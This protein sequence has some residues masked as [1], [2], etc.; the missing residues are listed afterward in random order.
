[1]SIG[2]LNRKLTGLR[3]QNHYERRRFN[4]EFPKPLGRSCRNL[5]SLL[6]PKPSIALIYSGD[7][8][9]TLSPSAQ[10]KLFETL[11]LV[12]PEASLK[13]ALCAAFLVI[14]SSFGNLSAQ[15]TSLRPQDLR[16]KRF[17]NSSTDSPGVAVLRRPADMHH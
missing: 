5:H 9:S 3:Q 2:T 13:R 11:Q 6:V 7:A 15:T 17:E 1:M 12:T 10:P 14:L 16:T 8:W 4:R